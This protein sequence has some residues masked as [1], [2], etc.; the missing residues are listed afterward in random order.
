[1]A[2]R[3]DMQ[4][5]DDGLT[6]ILGVGAALLLYQSWMTRIPQGRALGS[7]LAVSLLAQPQPS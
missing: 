3:E 5:S 1:M 2:E 6:A 7:F 4:Q